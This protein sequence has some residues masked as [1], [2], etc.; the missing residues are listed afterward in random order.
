MTRGRRRL[1]ATLGLRRPPR[2]AQRSHPRQRPYSAFSSAAGRRPRFSRPPKVIFRRS[3]GEEGPALSGA[4]ARRPPSKHS[5]RRPPL[6]SSQPPAPRRGWPRRRRQPR[7][8]ACSRT[9]TFTCTRSAA[10]NGALHQP[11]RRVPTLS[12]NSRDASDAIP[13]R[14]A[15]PRPLRRRRRRLRRPT[16]ALLDRYDPH[17][18]FA[19][20]VLLRAVSVGATP[21][22]ARG[23]ATPGARRRRAGRH[24]VPLIGVG[25]GSFERLVRSERR[26]ARRRSTSPWAPP[27]RPRAPVA[28]PPS[29]APS[30]PA[31]SA[32]P[33]LAPSPTSRS[34]P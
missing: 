3:A 31:D 17:V 24:P 20:G 12:R 16:G 5:R 22:C 7:G 29:S 10:S 18:V 34:P 33:R 28:T 23:A 2:A 30:P 27:P 21:L 14:S 6:A 11:A 26:D 8:S 9:L 15:P 32:R 25:D 19:S 1:R 4:L 13:P